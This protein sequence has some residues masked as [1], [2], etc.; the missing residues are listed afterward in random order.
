[1]KDYEMITVKAYLEKTENDYETTSLVDY[2]MAS[3]ESDAKVEESI[4]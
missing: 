4:A 1:M 2:L 3:L